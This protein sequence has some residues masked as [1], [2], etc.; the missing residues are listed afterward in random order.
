MKQ[1]Q[2]NRFNG[3]YNNRSRSV[4]MRNTV[5]ESSGPCGKLHGTPLQLFEKYQTAAKDALIQNDLI[6]SETCLQYADH[7]I[8][9]QNI[10]I[11]NE[12]GRNTS[13][14]VGQSNQQSA[15][16]PKKEDDE[17]KDEIPN[18]SLETDPLNSKPLDGSSE[19]EPADHSE[20][21]SLAIQNM[22]LSI[23]ILTIQENHMPKE[24]RARKNVKRTRKPKNQL[25]QPIEA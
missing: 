3:R 15:G 6:L 16:L 20:V 21:D 4:I 9:L 8:R 22:D 17:T 24:E 1:N 12:Q 5:L 11:A 2:K 18:F 13:N 7:Y 14:C 19:T 10:A 23:P 25:E